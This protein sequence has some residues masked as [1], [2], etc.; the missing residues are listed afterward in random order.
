M[1]TRKLRTVE[2]LILITFPIVLFA[3]CAGNDIKPTS[4]GPNEEGIISEL[5]ATDFG[6]GGISA[7]SDSLPVSL[8]QP[9]KE[10]QIAD[11]TTAN[12]SVTN[13]GSE[14]NPVSNQAN[15]VSIAI[16]DKK[17]FFFNTNIYTLTEKQREELKHHAEYLKANP[18]TVLVINGHADERGSEY[19]NQTLSEKRALE[20]YQF[21]IKAGVTQDQLV[22]KGF[23]EL[24]PM[25]SESN[26]DENRRV[27]LEYT[28]PM[29]LSSM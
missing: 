29:M 10:E 9:A 20:T 7:E 21:L 6:D 1:S 25:H 15:D 22:K 4:G 3:G 8:V 24:V 16:P 26:W 28:D 27:E 13:K 18:G 17:I 5:Q 12:I 11:D 14:L 19:Y 2:N 23:G